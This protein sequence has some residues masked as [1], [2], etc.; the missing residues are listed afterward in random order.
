MCGYIQWVLRS[1]NDLYIVLK[2]N[3]NHCESGAKD[4]DEPFN[5][6][7]SLTSHSASGAGG[8]RAGLFRTPISGGVQSATSA[9]GLPRPSLAVRNLMEQVMTFFCSSFMPFSFYQM[10]HFFSPEQD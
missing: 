8:T 7:T 1:F 10:D 5:E 2:G 9:H 6:G 4:V 3:L